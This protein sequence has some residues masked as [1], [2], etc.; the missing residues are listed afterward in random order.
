MII[1]L[2]QILHILF[3][4]LSQDFDSTIL[5]RHILSY[6]LFEHRLFYSDKSYLTPSMKID[7]FIPSNFILRPLQTSII[8]FL[9]ILLFLP[10]SVRIIHLQKIDISTPRAPVNELNLLGKRWY[11]KYQISHLK[12]QKW[13][14]FTT[15]NWMS[16]Q[17]TGH[18]SIEP[19]IA[20]Y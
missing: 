10:E 8:L 13:L 14:F 4:S 17:K 11:L 20:L 1:L 16:R 15:K 9:Q 2:R 6:A 19:R 5:L 7:Y 12:V 3:Y 18:F